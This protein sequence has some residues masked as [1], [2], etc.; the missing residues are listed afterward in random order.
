M[1]AL[2]KT[3]NNGTNPSQGVV[4]KMSAVRINFS[5]ISVV[6]AVKIAVTPVTTK[7]TLGLPIVNSLRK[8][9]NSKTR[10]PNK[11]V[12]KPIISGV[13]I[14]VFFNIEFSDAD[15]QSR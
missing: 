12:A 15:K 8:Q 7:K 9:K 3:M 4:R 13:C 11:R 14:D 1:T 6:I 10:L 2:Q 5:L